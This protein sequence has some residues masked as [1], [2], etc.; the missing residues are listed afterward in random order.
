[1]SHVTLQSHT[2]DTE[3]GVVNNSGTF[4]SGEYRVFVQLNHSAEHVTVHRSMAML[5]VLGQ[6][7]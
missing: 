4:H 3:G 5:V 1:V 7:D 2:C 6:R